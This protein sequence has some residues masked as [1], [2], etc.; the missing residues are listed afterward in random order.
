[1]RIIERIRSLAKGEYFRPKLFAHHNWGKLA[2]KRCAQYVDKLFR[3]YS[4]YTVIRIDLA[5]KAAHVHHIS[6]SR[7]K[8]G[9]DDF[10]HGTYADRPPVFE[11]MAGYIWKIEFGIQSGF[12]FHLLLFFR[13]VHGA[14]ARY[15]ADELGKFW[16]VAVTAG[17]GRF[18]N[19]NAREYKDNALGEINRSDTEKVGYLY[20]RVLAYLFKAEQRIPVR[21]ADKKFRSFGTGE[22]PR[23]LFEDRPL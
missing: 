18:D 1:M 3:R 17:A 12:H 2:F 16:S 8:Q 5:Y 4:R 7:A 11:E 15:W 13:N 14:R 21:R 6:L 20:N 22:L 19:C 9:L 10:L 23:F